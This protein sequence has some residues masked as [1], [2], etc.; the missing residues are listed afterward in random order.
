MFALDSL[1]GLRGAV[2]ASEGVEE[3]LQEDLELLEDGA[4]AEESGDLCAGEN[5]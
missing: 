1:T 4:K 5:H 2:Q 3:T